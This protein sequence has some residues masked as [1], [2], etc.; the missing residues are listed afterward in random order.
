ME[1]ARHRGLHLQHASAPSVCTVALLKMLGIGVAKIDTTEVAHVSMKAT[2][3]H[4]LL[5]AIAAS[6]GGAATAVPLN[7]WPRARMF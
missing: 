6:Q 2:A 3:Y 5:C 4:A 7:A 1:N